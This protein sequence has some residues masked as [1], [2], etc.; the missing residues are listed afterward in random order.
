M[1]NIVLCGGLGEVAKWR[2]GLEGLRSSVG[3][4]CS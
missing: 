4:D 1:N 2:N 3:E